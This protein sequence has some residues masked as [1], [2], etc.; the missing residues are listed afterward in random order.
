MINRKDFQSFIV[1]N[2]ISEPISKIRRQP[3]CPFKDADLD[4]FQ[5]LTSTAVKGQSPPC[6]VYL[7]LSKV[8]TCSAPTRLHWAAHFSPVHC[9]WPALHTLGGLK[10]HK[11]NRQR[12]RCK[13]PKETL[14]AA[15]PGVASLLYP[16]PRLVRASPMETRTVV[17]FQTASLVKV[18][19]RRTLAAAHALLPALPHG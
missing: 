16:V 1:W 6:R 14:G 18:E 12:Q 15:V 3:L 9:H 17:S 19:A 5:N 13:R 10:G 4:V 8:V 7:F 11:G 2:W